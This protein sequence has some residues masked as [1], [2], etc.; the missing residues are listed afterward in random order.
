MAVAIF[1]LAIAA[2]GAWL[3]WE[4]AAAQRARTQN[5]VETVSPDLEPVVATADTPQTNNG[6]ASP[7]LAADTSSETSSLAPAGTYQPKDNTLEIQSS[8]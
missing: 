8:E 2:I 5:Q 7:V 6:K 4:S 3:W 1:L